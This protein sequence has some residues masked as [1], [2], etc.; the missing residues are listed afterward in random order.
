MNNKSSVIKAPDLK[1]DINHQA[2]LI[3]H[4]KN[5][6]FTSKRIINPTSIEVKYFVENKTVY[7][8]RHCEYPGLEFLSFYTDGQEA[9]LNS[10]EL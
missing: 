2:G 1:V 3:E 4:M 8:I 7:G 10:C 9:S 6:F 5:K